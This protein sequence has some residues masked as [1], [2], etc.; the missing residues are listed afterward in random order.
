MRQS[1]FCSGPM[2]ENLL[3]MR[4]R[5][6]PALCRPAL[7]P[8]R[9]LSTGGWPICEVFACSAAPTEACSPE[10]IS[11]PW[12]L[13]RRSATPAHCRQS[14][15]ARRL[16]GESFN[17]ASA[18]SYRITFALVCK[19]NDLLC[20]HIGCGIGAVDQVKS[21]QCALKG[22]GHDGDLIWPKRSAL[23]KTTEWHDEP[24]VVP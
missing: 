3:L 18:Q 5:E 9:A 22:L 6:L 13:L 15:V 1:R 11:V 10:G 20:D 14:R 2:R 17:R 8:P 24:P 21:A 7:E 16:S 23:Q 4:R 19:L 12:S